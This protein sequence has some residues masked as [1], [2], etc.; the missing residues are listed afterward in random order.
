MELP[1]GSLLRGLC[2]SSQASQRP[3]NQQLLLLDRRG[4]TPTQSWMLTNTA[5]KV[6]A[7]VNT[8]AAF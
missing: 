6:L 2:A 5:Q 1:E 7:E 3:A 8:S 4:M